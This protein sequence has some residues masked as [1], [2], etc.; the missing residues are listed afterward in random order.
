VA[1]VLFLSI[2]WVDGAPFSAICTT[3]KAKPRID[4]MRGF[5]LLAST[6]SICCANNV[7]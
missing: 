3:N 5:A 6:H 7:R 2:C 4:V 1:I